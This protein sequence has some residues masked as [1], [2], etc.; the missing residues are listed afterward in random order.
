VAFRSEGSIR[1]TKAVLQVINLLAKEQPFE[2]YGKLTPL[3][4]EPSSSAKSARVGYTRRVFFSPSFGRLDVGITNTLPHGK[5]VA[6]ARKL[7]NFTHEA[8]NRADA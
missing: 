6:N 2:A 3:F 8:R 7:T 4:D 5:A 1:P